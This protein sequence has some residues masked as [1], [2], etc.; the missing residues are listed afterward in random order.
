MNNY[1]VSMG[2]YS[3]CSRK[4]GGGNTKNVFQKKNA[5]NQT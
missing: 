5:E 3:I 1:N 4:G 2:V